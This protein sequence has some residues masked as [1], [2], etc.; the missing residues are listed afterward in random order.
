VSIRFPGART[1]ISLR[2]DSV[3]T[4]DYCAEAPSQIVYISPAAA[5]E[6][7]LYDVG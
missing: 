4:I 7:Q 6:S 1:A 5:S 2:L 3:A